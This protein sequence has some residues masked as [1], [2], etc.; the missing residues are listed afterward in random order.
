M[1]ASSASF[2]RDRM[3]GTSLLAVWCIVTVCTWSVGFLSS[4]LGLP[5][6][7]AFRIPSPAMSRGQLRGKVQSRNAL[8]ISTSKFQSASTSRLFV[9]EVESTT[10]EYMF[11]M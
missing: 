9:H 10:G 3:K 5:I 2:S 4:Q 8:S 7:T 11:C 1:S 6:T